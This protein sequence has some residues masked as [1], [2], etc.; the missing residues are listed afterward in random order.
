VYAELQ[1]ARAEQGHVFD[2]FFE[3]EHGQ[4]GR[5]SFDTAWVRPWEKFLGEYVDRLRNPMGDL[6]RF[7]RELFGAMFNQGKLWG[8]WKALRVASK[9]RPVHLTLRFGDDTHAL[10]ALP[11]ELLY[12]SGSNGGFLFTQRG[13]ALVR[14]LLGVRQEAW[15][16]PHGSPK[17]LFAWACPTGVGS[18]F[19]GVEHFK[20][21]Q[22]CSNVELLEKV[23]REA[24]EE[25]LKKKNVDYLVLLAH[26]WKEHQEMGVFLDGPAPDYVSADDL[27]NLVKDTG[28]RL[29]FLCSCQTA[30]PAAD[31]AA[32]MFSGVA[33][34]MLNEVLCV[35]A[36]QAALP[37]LGSAELTAMFFQQLATGITP[38]AAVAKARN[39][40]HREPAWSVPVIY[41]RSRSLVRAREPGPSAQSLNLDYEPQVARF[42]PA[43][44]A[45]APVGNGIDLDGH[46]VMQ[47]A[48]V[49]GP[50][51]EQP[52]QRPR[53]ECEQVIPVSAHPRDPQTG[54]LSVPRFHYGSV[55]PP[56]YF[57]GREEQLTEARETIRACQSFLIV[58]SHRAG[59]TSFCK[60]LIHELMGNSEKQV[61]AAYLNLQQLIDLNVETFLEHTLLNLMGEIARQVFGCKYTD[62]MRADFPAPHPGSGD[63]TAFK[64]FAHIFRL[65]Q[66]HTRESRATVAPL[67]AQEFIQFNHDL[68]EIVRRQGWGNVVIFY[69]E[70]NRLPRELSVDLLVSNEEA[71]NAAGV[72]SVYVASPA[73]MDAFRPVYDSF[74]REVRL[75][76][77]SNIEDL[78]HLLARYYF[79]DAARIEDLPVSLDAIDLLWRVT[80]GRP[81]PIQLVA[82]RSFECARTRGAHNVQACH[83]EEAHRALLAEKPQCFG[84]E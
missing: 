21:L 10:A 66:S 65:V 41:V 84:G 45:M 26:G 53:M 49:T 44:A 3:D 73:M 17:I 5:G 9:G 29:V 28:V 16:P 70:A 67:G 63:A 4:F 52:L 31:P 34:R 1:V 35:V 71:L 77:F 72:I 13:S 11:L 47:H 22:T 81:F 69:D 61:L 60:K 18:P 68:L 23:T 2:L 57:I 51:P 7:G 42:Q 40:Y 83:V 24:L 38:A 62:L 50:L 20:Q 80:G 36:M 75:G 78:R 54:G 14:T 76:S 6:V 39:V 12:E 48:K 32:G 74:G 56:P 15:T 30:Q 37:I 59:K 64:S 43:A 19:T 55:V 33:Q 82:G 79:G 27:A 58:G 25:R 46:Q 8:C